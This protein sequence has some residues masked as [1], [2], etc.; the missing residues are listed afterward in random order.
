MDIQLIVTPAY[1]H[2]HDSNC[3]TD[4]NITFKIEELGGQIV[5]SSRWRMIVKLPVD[6]VGTFLLWARENSAL[7]SHLEFTLAGD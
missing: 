2:E 3:D 4:L 6:N 7:F 1:S 5:E